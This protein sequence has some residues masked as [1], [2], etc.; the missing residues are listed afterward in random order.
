MI[1]TC[2]EKSFTTNKEEAIAMIN[3]SY[4]KKIEDLRKRID[5]YE[6][7]RK[8]DLRTLDGM[9]GRIQHSFGKMRDAMSLLLEHSS[10][11]Y[12]DLKYDE[13]SDLSLSE[14]NEMICQLRETLSQ[15][16]MM[17]RVKPEPC[18]LKKQIREKEL[19]KEK[20]NPI[21][22]FRFYKYLFQKPSK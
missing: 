22:L 11:V 18:D 3:E 20:E 14:E 7:R 6:T 5:A 15:L 17:F 12:D 13:S 1:L 10:H 16:R 8:S 21:S 19:E 4:A 2:D 9:E